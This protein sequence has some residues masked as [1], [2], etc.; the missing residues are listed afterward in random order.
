MLLGLRSKKV[1]FLRH[2]FVAMLSAVLVYAFYL[3]YPS[4]GV[5]FAWW[6][7]WS[8]SH[9][10]WRSFAHAAFV[11]LF[12]TLII[13]PAAKLWPACARFISWR[14]ELGIWFAVLAIGHGYAIWDRWATWDIQRLFGLEYLE[15]VGSYVMFRPEV[16]IMNMM[17]IAIFPMIVALAIT[18]S[19]RLVNILGIASWKWLH[20]TLVTVIFYTVVLRGVLYLFFF[21]QPTLPDLRFYPSIWFLY[22][23]L[24]MA[25]IVVLLQAAAFVKTVFQNRGGMWAT[26]QQSPLHVLVSIGIGILFT[27]PMVLVTASVVFLDSRITVTPLSNMTASI[28][29]EYATSFE[30]VLHEN[31]GQEARIWAQDLDTTPYFRQTIYVEGVPVAHQV[32]QFDTQ[33]LRSAERNAQGILVWTENKNVPPQNTGLGNVLSGPGVWAA[34]YGVGEHTIQIGDQTVPVTIVSVNEEIKQSVFTISDK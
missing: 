22:P 5:T 26:F 15:T 7:D 21:F 10:F 23:F 2:A 17:A 31:N 20:S 24:G 34:T 8:V 9:P 14:R 11:L 28:T 12:L 27:L 19:D 13:G 18:S 25:V 32:Y 30:M 33:T 4:W 1:I 29:E 16:G 6:P 3:S